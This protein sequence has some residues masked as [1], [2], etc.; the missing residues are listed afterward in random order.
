MVD[1]TTAIFQYVYFIPQKAKSFSITYFCVSC[2]SINWIHNLRRYFVFKVSAGEI[3]SCWNIGYQSF[4]GIIHPGQFYMQ[5]SQRRRG[6]GENGTKRHN[7][8]RGSSEL[9]IKIR[10]PFN[11]KIW[12]QKSIQFG[13]MIRPLIHPLNICWTFGINTLIHIITLFEIAIVL[14]RS[15]THIQQNETT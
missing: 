11:L 3:E 8:V 6:R 5:Y 10:K 4:I 1:F 7:C 2:Y 13:F 15:H 14:P 12:K 9:R